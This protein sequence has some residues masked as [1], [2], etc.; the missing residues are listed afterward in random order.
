LIGSHGSRKVDC[1]RYV[2]NGEAQEMEGTLNVASLLERLGLE[3]RRVAV[4]INTAVIPR[5]R[6]DEFEIKEGD[7]IEVIQAVGGG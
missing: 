3:R 2:L 7:R 6:F 4:A 1:V 5:S